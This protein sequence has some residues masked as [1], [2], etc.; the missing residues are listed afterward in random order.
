M[1]QMCCRFSDSSGARTHAANQ[2]LYRVMNTRLC[3]MRGEEGRSGRGLYIFNRRVLT[4]SL[5]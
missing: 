1:A 5:V 3:C 4:Q 2:A